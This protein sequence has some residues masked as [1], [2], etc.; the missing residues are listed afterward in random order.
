MLLVQMKQPS[1]LSSEVELKYGL[2]NSGACKEDEVVLVEIKCP[3]N[4][5]SEVEVKGSVVS[6][7]VLKL[8]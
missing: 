8:I 1:N 3:L 5:L 7:L 4:I 6:S 2:V